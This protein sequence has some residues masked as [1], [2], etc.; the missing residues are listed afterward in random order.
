LVLDNQAYQQIERSKRLSYAKNFLTAL[1]CRNKLP[2]FVIICGHGSSTLNNLFAAKLQCGACGNYRGSNNARLMA[3][4]LND[5][6]V[7]HDL[8]TDEKLCLKDTVFIAAEH[9]TTDDSIT[10]YDIPQALK[11][12][13]IW[14]R[15]TNDLQRVSR[16]NY[17]KRAQLLRTQRLSPYHWAAVRPEWGLAG[18]QAFLIGP[19]WWG[20]HLLQSGQAFSHSYNDRDDNDGAVLAGIFQGPLTVAFLLSMPYLLGSFDSALFAA[21]NKMLHQLSVGSMVMQG[22]GS[23]FLI[24]LPEQAIHIQSGKL[25]HRPQRLMLLVYSSRYKVRKV[26]LS[27]PSLLAKIVNGWLRMMVYD[28]ILNRWFE[29]ADLLAATHITPTGVEA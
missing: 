14:L 11:A 17:D 4:I 13:P 3:Q 2:P 9:D 28:P 21:G 19:H 8:L 24:G 18:H 6:H 29:T 22:C 7:Q 23:D 25:Y 10:F 5:R 27:Q 1:H 12:H 20:A 16:Q 26:L 15:I